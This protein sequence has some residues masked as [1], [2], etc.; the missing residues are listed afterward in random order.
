MKKIISVFLII[1][2]MAVNSYSQGLSFR[3]DSVSA[4]QGDSVVVPVYVSG[5]QDVGSFTLYIGYNNSMTA[6]GRGLNWHAGLVA[7]QP[8]V[9]AG[10]GKIILAWANA[11]G[12]TIAD[13]KLLDFKFKY[14]G[15]QWPFS[16]TSNCEVTDTVGIAISPAPTYISGLVVPRFEINVT[17]S[18]SIICLQDSS[19]LSTNSE[20]GFGDYVYQWTSDPIGFTSTEA[21]PSVAPIVPTTYYVTVTDGP[22]IETGQ[23][24]IDIYPAIQPSAVSNMMPADGTEDLTIPVTLSWFPG[25]NATKYDVY[26]W[27][28]GQS[29]IGSLR[30]MN[31]TS[32][33]TSYAGILEYEK[34]YSWQVAAKNSCASTLGP[35][36]TFQMRYIPDLVISNI[37]TPSTIYAGQ[38]LTVSWTVNNQGLGET[39]STQWVDACYLSLDTIFGSGDIKIGQVGNLAALDTAESYVMTSEFTIPSSL[40]GNFFVIMVADNSNN[41]YES[42]E[43]NNYL[44]DPSGAML[45]I[46]LPPQPDL[47]ATSIGVP[48]S[49]YSGNTVN[50]NYSVKNDGFAS[51]QGSQVNYYN[52]PGC[53][54]YERYWRDQIYISPEST[55]SSSTAIPLTGV[56]IGLRSGELG[57]PVSCSLDWYSYSDFLPVDSSYSR[58][59]S[60]VIPHNIYGTYYF[61]VLADRNASSGGSLVNELVETNNWIR[62]NAVDVILT[63]PPNLEVNYVTSSTSAVS[64]ETI[65][66][67]WETENTGANP[68]VETIWR[69][70]IYLSQVDTFNINVST[71]ISTKY[72]YGGNALVPFS[73][74]TDSIYYTLPNGIS[75]QYYVYV[76][77]DAFNEVFEYLFDDDNI[78]R[79]L[80]LN[81]TLSPYPD[82][83]IVDITMGQITGTGDVVPISWTVK[84]QGN[85]PASG[86]WYDRVFLSSNP[87]WNPNGTATLLSQTHTGGLPVGSTYTKSSSFVVPQTS[88]GS[89]YVYVYTD[90]GNAVYEYNYEGNNVANAGYFEDTTI[91]TTQ[92]PPPIVIVADTLQS[93]LNLV[94]VSAPSTAWTGQTYSFSWQVNNIGEKATNQ[95]QWVDHIYLSTDNQLSSDDERII[96][97]YH[98]GTLQVGGLYNAS[99]SVTFG[100]N[101]VGTYY[102]LMRIDHYD[103]ET[104]E[105]DALNNRGVQSIEIF[106]SPPP[107]L[108]VDGLTSP[109]NAIAGQY[110]SVNYEVLNQGTG[111]TIHYPFH[112]KLYLST[113]PDLSGWKTVIGSRS[114]YTPLAANDSYTGTLGVTIPSWANGYYFLVYACDYN[115]L[116]FENGLDGNNFAYQTISIT[117][118]APSDLRF[119]ALSMPDSITLGDDVSI[120]YTIENIGQNPAVGSLRD[121]FYFSEDTLFDGAID[122]LL[123]VKDR[124]VYI[125]PGQ[126][127]SGTISGKT[128]NVLPGDYHGVGRTNILKSIPESDDTNND[129]ITESQLNVD[130][131]VLELD[132]PKNKSLDIGD[133]LYYRI[134]VAAD[135][136]LLVTLTSNLGYGANEIYVAYDRVPAVNDFDF[137]FEY[138]QS[139]DQMVLVPS[140]S[141]G[142]YYVLIKTPYNSYGLQTVEILAQA[143]PFSILVI[144]PDT[145]GAGE[146]T[147]EF[148]GAGFKTNTQFWLYNGSNPVVQGS[149]ANFINSMN[150]QVYWNLDTIPLGTYDVVAINPDTT[151]TQVD[152]MTIEESTG[153]LVDFNYISPTLLRVGRQGV[154]TFYFRNIGNVD[155]PYVK[156]GIAVPSYTNLEALNVS[157]GIMLRSDLFS[158][159]DLEIEEYVDMGGARVIPF[160]RKDL[161]AGE[162]MTVN[163]VV[164]G[165]SQ[166]V[167]NVNV[168]AFGYSTADYIWDQLHTAELTR[169]YLAANPGY[170][171]FAQTP[172]QQAALNDC[173][174]FRDSIYHTMVLMGLVTTADSVGVDLSCDTLTSGSE[175]GLGAYSYG[176][177]FTY[178]PGTSPGIYNTPVADFNS[179]EDYLWE[180]NKYAGAPGADPGWDII[181]CSSSININSTSANPFVLRIASLNYWNQPDYL[182]GW[183]PAVDKCWP[184]AIADGG[185][186]NFDTAKFAI[187]L[188]R[189]TDHNYTYGGK[190]SLALQGTD[191]ILLCFTAYVPGPGEDGV[192]GTP[193]APGEDGS[194]GGKGGPG[195][196]NLGILPGA[197]GVGGAGGPG[198]PGIGLEPGDGGPGGPGGDGDVGQDGGP[199]GQGGAGGHGGYGQAGGQ[200]GPG[201]P[202]GSGGINGNGGV[203]GPGGP[204]G[205]AGPVLPPSITPPP[206]PGGP[207]GP[208]GPAGT[209]SSPNT[210]TPGSNGPNGP[211]GG[212]TPSSPSTNP[213]TPGSPPSPGPGGSNSNNSGNNNNQNINDNP[214]PNSGPSNSGIPCNSADDAEQ[215]FC[216]KILPAVSCGWGALG[217]VGFLAGA[218]AASGGTLTWLTGTIGV[219]GCVAALSTCIKHV[220]GVDIGVP[221][222]VSLIGCL[223]DPGS[224]AICVLE[225]ICSAVVKSCDPNDIIGPRGYG[226]GRFVAQNELLPYTIR[227]ENDAEFATTAAQRVE[228]KQVIPPTLN[229]LSIRLST[230]GFGEYIFNV[231]ENSASYFQVLDM[232]DSL[233]WDLEVT[234][235]IDIV[236]NEAFWIFQTIDPTTGQPPV[237]ALTGFLAINDSTGSGEGFVGYTVLP[238]TNTQT[239]DT[240]FAEAE[241]VFDINDPILTPLIF[242]TID[243]G[244]PSSTVDA[245]PQI[246]DSTTISIDII[247]ADDQGGSGIQSYELYYSENGGPWIMH[248]NFQLGE[249]VSFTG[250]NNASYGFFSRA[251]DNVN[252]KEPIKNYAE[253]TTII[254]PS[255]LSLGGIVSY[256]N[257][258]NTP[259]QGAMIVAKDTL[260]N[261]VDTAFSDNIGNYYFSAL[262][263]DNYSLETSF[264]EPWGGGNATDALIINKFT[265]SAYTLSDFR[266]LAADVNA[267]TIINATDGLLIKR[268]TI[269]SISSFP[270]GD[271]LVEQ[272]E[273]L[274]DGYTVVDIAAI[275]FGDVNGSYNPGL[276]PYSKSTSGKVDLSSWGQVSAVSGSEIV[277]DISMKEELEAGAIT[278]HIDFDADVLDLLNVSSEIP[279]LMYHVENGVLS[280]AWES[281]EPIMFSNDD[282]VLSLQF[283]AKSTNESIVTYLSAIYESEFADRNAVVYPKVTLTYPEINILKKGEYALNHN[284]PNPFSDYT[285]ISYSMPEA[286]DVQLMVYNSL[287]E[288]IGILVNKHQEAGHHKVRFD[289]GDLA[290]GI[291]QY[292]ISI[293][294]ESQMF[295]KTNMMMI[296]K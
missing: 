41:L 51:A 17:A 242:N 229:P 248:K 183:Y 90:Y 58:N 78:K 29:P 250:L 71:L 175:Y 271:W 208:G 67:K 91:N 284:Y 181:R 256:D 1:A 251:M 206:G 290:S 249:P 186:N 239:G 168:Y 14:Q 254:N 193:G 216:N 122:K 96:E 202:G 198:M 195:D 212:N 237:D 81:I 296:N 18:P 79:S 218:T 65:K 89:Y 194:P 166:S 66:V 32:I 211:N 121:A 185:V 93:D 235:G 293:N 259:I 156:A 113:S 98:Y 64:G 200:G 127:L 151:I 84:N 140:T 88:S 19:L 255:G 62:S 172:E 191:T 225:E 201:G 182:A 270:S 177:D 149:M 72:H 174:A 257:T 247:A 63:P 50:V 104:N 26:I 33:N 289:G 133:V 13:G 159:L 134:D 49:F 125:Q 20:W 153:F 31:I 180:I 157:N 197:G 100:H 145:V 25:A 263:P 120:N 295:S 107:D 56:Y 82:L 129:T 44:V 10:A 138:P 83:T 42:N 77:T 109:A 287:G 74:Y 231:P 232:P 243:A 187:D 108:I 283:R 277:V 47:I 12:A 220:T 240:I 37:L 279:E 196:S 179:G 246:S 114:E 101:K 199:G 128:P 124:G 61:Y 291:Y 53:S 2:A 55:Y 205:S 236:D 8:L 112:D 169:A 34:N 141:A 43:D 188:T 223:G 210:T 294:G 139:A 75:G 118:P 35:I 103:W 4:T 160:V 221:K 178:S 131:E 95:S 57:I 5:F 265:V 226:A 280:I 217:C 272:P 176:N 273:F 22:D 167:F 285:E 135:L 119:S 76:H 282:H 111:P 7:D 281:L 3:V 189:F 102:L 68:P 261:P 230:F 152:G 173:E 275:C 59:V 154:Y 244:M 142:S 269:G 288:F 60:V 148:F 150:V 158:L 286:G 27:E 241:I 11:D 48:T 80:P 46:Q 15:Q 16:F 147:N 9:N 40:F 92:P 245:L 234:A 192:P 252:Y 136:D 267:N 276:I 36:Q 164:S 278:L 222:G 262:P 73:T 106:F 116:V 219:A 274:L 70:K 203:G 213:T 21:E 23:V 54:F 94:S 123:S 233:G 253:A 143:L 268:R 97:K 204:G 184:I 132:I 115:D 227:F 137:L 52:I 38:P 170:Y 30:K 6:W 105:L 28:T 207:G 99:K 264:N 224:F 45:E 165:F 117:Q 126:T 238:K 130:I 86:S 110:I 24:F 146:V 215:E 155:I 214:N 171:N 266:Q 260:G 292:K 87:N 209:P 161:T 258:A 39:Y 228:I 162:I 190:F 163:M 85:G 69:D 144:N